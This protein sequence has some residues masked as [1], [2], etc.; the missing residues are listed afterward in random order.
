MEVRQVHKVDQNLLP[1][2]ISALSSPAFCLLADD[3]SVIMLE[4]DFVTD[5]T[6]FSM[7]FNLD[8]VGHK[9]TPQYFWISTTKY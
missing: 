9:Q 3:F 8:N 2:F 4:L 1:H 7:L 6:I 5:E